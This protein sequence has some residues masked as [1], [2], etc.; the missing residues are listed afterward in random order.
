MIDWEN[1][2]TDSYER[3]LRDIVLRQ[4]SV[5]GPWLVVGLVMALA[6]F[7]SYLVYSN[8]L[9]PVIGPMSPETSWR[10]MTE[11]APATTVSLPAE[12]DFFPLF[13]RG[14]ATTSVPESRAKNALLGGYGPALLPGRFAVTAHDM[15]DADSD[16]AVLPR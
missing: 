3:H 2:H 6:F 4:H 14:K 9:L 12:V 13:R 1:S 16:M 8:L 15:P 10:T 7:L 5:A 11:T